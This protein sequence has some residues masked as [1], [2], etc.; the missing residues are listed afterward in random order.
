MFLRD[1]YAKSNPFYSFVISFY[2]YLQSRFLHSNLSP[3]FHR[4]DQYVTQ[5]DEM[6]RQLAAAEDEKKTLNTLL[7]MAIQQKLALTQRLED[8]ETPL[9]PLSNGGSPRHS[10]TKHLTK[11]GRAPRS[12]MRSSPRSSPVLVPTGPQNMSSHLRVL[13]RSLHSSPVRVPS[14]SSSCSSF[15]AEPESSTSTQSLASVGL[16]RDTTFVRSYGSSSSRSLDDSTGGLGPFAIQSRQPKVHESQAKGLKVSAPSRSNTFIKARRT[17]LPATKT[18]SHS[19]EAL[20]TRL[21]RSDGSEK[22]RKVTMEENDLK[23][24]K[25]SNA[26]RAFLKKQSNISK[27]RSAEG[28]AL[29][30]FACSNTASTTQSKFLPRAT[31]SVASPITPSDKRQKSSFPSRAKTSSRLA[32]HSNS[33]RDFEEIISNPSREIKRQQDHLQKQQGGVDAANR[34]THTFTRQTK[35]RAT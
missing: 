4:C 34:S 22:R 13:S 33:C 16:V 14:S 29:S 7:R 17:S 8:L 6:Q 15:S 19:V 20:A 5:L 10:R 35:F 30:R 2:L 27:S 12:P 23:L 28:T 32:S 26:E 11:S 31:S 1:V 18:G 24:S 3:C 9:S 21:G 25:K